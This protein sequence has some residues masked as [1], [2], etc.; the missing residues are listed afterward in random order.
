MTFDNTKPIKTVNFNGEDAPLDILNIA[1]GTTPPSDVT[2]LWVP[3]EN[4]PSAVE[5]SGDSL[6][7]A[8]DTLRTM[9]ATLSQTASISPPS[10]EFNGKIYIFL[11][12]NT[13]QVFDPA[14]DTCV[15]KSFTSTYNYAY[16]MAVTIGSKIYLLGGYYDAYGRNGIQ[17]YDPVTNTCVAKSAKL[18]TAAYRGSVVAINGKAYVF[19]GY[20]YSTYGTFYNYIQEYDPATDTC[21]KKNATLTTPLSVTSAVVINGKAYIFGGYK[22]P[23]YYNN[24]QEYDPITDTC[25]EKSTKLTANAGYTS[26]VAMNGKAYIFGG[27]DS[28][29]YNYVQ[30]YDPATNAISV[31]S[32]LFPTTVS[33][34]GAS[35]IND[36]A[37]IFGGYANNGASNAK[38]FYEYTAKAYLGANHLKIFASVYRG[39]AY[40]VV[41]NI[42]NNKN[43]QVKLYMTSAFIG[44]DDGYAKEQD[45]YVF[46]KEK[47]QW[48]ALDGTSMT[49]DMLNALAELGVT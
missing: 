1:Y 17:E 37:Y 38:T 46:N 42:V 12:A 36:K 5:V 39:E 32:A 13:V 40:Q 35:V 33:A 29:H 45:A 22:N 9:N 48:Q 27:R 3:L 20:T 34:T 26:A 44:D 25:V 18:D 30:E 7:S 47:Q 19:G 28:S 41:T 24:I 16:P 11:N 10:A 8:V 6:Q 2:R 49:T 31:K 43:A 23:S 15:T 4:R 14:T 21:V